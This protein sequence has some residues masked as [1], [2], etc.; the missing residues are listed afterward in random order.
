MGAASQ[1]ELGST[2][3]VEVEEATAVEVRGASA[4]PD[5]DRLMEMAVGK[6][7]E[8]VEALERLVE[9]R[10][11][12]LD[13]EAESALNE[14]VAEFRA[15]CPPI[16]KSRTAEIV[17]RK[18]GKFSFQYASLDDIQETID[19]L[20]PRYGLSYT[21][22]TDD[23]DD[24]KLVVTCR[25]SHVDG[26]FR[27]GRFITKTDSTG[28]M[29]AAQETGAANTY[30]KRQALVN[31]LGLRVSDADSDE[32]GPVETGEPLTDAQ[33]ADLEALA[34]EVG[35]TDRSRNLICELFGIE[36]FGTA[37]QAFYGALVRHVEAKRQ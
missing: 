35:L 25:V 15:N 31:A 23:T 24:G 29:S 36:S 34:D 16:Q 5:V 9:M 33:L 27:V 28:R 2:E 7:L 6:G 11:R 10:L 22:D 13:R 1:I 30:A 3:V 18:G 4:L 26:A 37:D 19:P 17:S 32:L 20:L 12:L 14:S 8:G 21:F